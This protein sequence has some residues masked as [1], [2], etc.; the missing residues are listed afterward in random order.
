MPA[1]TS[2]NNNPSD[3]LLDLCSDKERSFV[4]AYMQTFDIE[5]SAKEAG[6]TGHL[7]R[8]GRKFLRRAKVRNCITALREEAAGTIPFNE[9]DVALLLWRESSNAKNTGTA[10]V[11]A[12]SKLADVL[13]MIE[14]P[15]MPGAKKV[16]RAQRREKDLDAAREVKTMAAKRA[17]ENAEGDLQ[18]IKIVLQQ[19]GNSPKAL[20]G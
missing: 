6:F 2:S 12:A 15:T 19:F 3:K 8:E 5:A 11:A 16:V 1:I 9:T 10:R 13:R 18:D 17:I 14:S 4:V 7:V 20:E